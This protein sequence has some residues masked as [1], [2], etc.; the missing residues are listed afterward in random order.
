MISSATPRSGLLIRL[1]RLRRDRRGVA[2]VEFAMILPVL[3]IFYLGLTELQ[4]G[5]SIKRKLA[6]VTRTLADL[7]TRSADLTKAELKNIFG[8]S[9]AIMR[10]HDDTGLTQMVVT[11]VGVT[12]VSEGV[13]SGTVAWSCGWNLKVLLPA[14]T[15]LKLKAGAYTVP[16]GFQNDATKSFI[17]VE[18]MYPFTP[19]I[20]Y[21]ITGTVN[22]KDSSP[23][24]I[25]DAERVK[26]PTGLL[27]SGMVCLG[28]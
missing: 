5:I 21:T 11:S 13:Y 3:I 6:L 15:D 12:K 4:P 17:L 9:G 8:A 18:T 23:W 19:N 26:P 22:L 1:A 28:A 27:P 25:R 10:P 7:T 24:P 14:A 16:T 20:G 2:A